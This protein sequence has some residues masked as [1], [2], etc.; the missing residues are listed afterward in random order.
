[1]FSIGAFEH[2]LTHFVKHF[3]NAQKGMLYKYSTCVADSVFWSV[4]TIRHN[5][6]FVGQQCAT[7]V[8][9]NSV[10]ISKNP[11]YTNYKGIVF[12]Y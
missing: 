12:L 1:M 9:T 8:S 5:V 2:G 3:R 10:S 11:P 6:F 4:I 7:T